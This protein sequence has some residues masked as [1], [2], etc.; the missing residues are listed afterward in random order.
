M[1]FTVLRYEF[2]QTIFPAISLYLVIFA[3]AVIARLGW[4]SLTDMPLFYLVFFGAVVILM[5]RFWQTM[6]G[7]E[8]YIMFSLPL[9]A[10]GHIAAQLANI[11]IY[12]LSTTAVIGSALILQGEALGHM[13]L[14][15]SPVI[16]LALFAEVTFS[17]FLLSVQ[18]AMVLVLANL[19]FCQGN[20]KVWIF[21]WTIALFGAVSIL[22]GTTAAFI[23]EYIVISEES[24]IFISNT[25]TTPAS[26]SFSLNTMLWLLM[27]S[28]TLIS[29]M[30]RLTRKYMLLS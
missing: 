17:M 15:L 21:L 28:P 23:D 19:P 24:G 10:S 11:L 25:Y 7:P 22:S 3:F 26:I 8:A 30:S 1:L 9:S 12:S 2:K 5:Y 29:L 27:I 4:F 18:V 13:L 20:R 14:S 6:Y 16:S